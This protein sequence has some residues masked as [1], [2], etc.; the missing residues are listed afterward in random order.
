MGLG[1]T[2]PAA[3]DIE[4]FTIRTENFRLPAGV[5]VPFYFQGKLCFFVEF[6]WIFSDRCDL[7]IC[8]KRGKKF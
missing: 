1:L 2:G 6:Q 4:T 3:G 5:E 7:I 8:S